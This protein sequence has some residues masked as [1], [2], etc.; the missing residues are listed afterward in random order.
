MSSQSGIG[1][2]GGGWGTHHSVCVLHRDPASSQSRGM[3]VA[4]GGSEGGGRQGGSAGL[5]PTARGQVF[6]LSGKARTWWHEHN[7]SKMQ[8]CRYGFSIARRRH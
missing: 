7:L 2:G 8:K 3:F 6:L 4:V 1:V 5:C